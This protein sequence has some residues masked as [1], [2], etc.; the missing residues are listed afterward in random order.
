MHAFDIVGEKD[1]QQFRLMQTFS[2]PVFREI[3]VW[4]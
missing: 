3:Q 1:G 2:Q 4:V